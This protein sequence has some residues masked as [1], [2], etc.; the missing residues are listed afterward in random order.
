MKKIYGVLLGGLLFVPLLAGASFDKNLYYGLQKDV[1]VKELQ[2]FLADQGLYSGPITGN[3]FSL[4]LSAVKKFQTANSISP[5]SGYFGPKSRTVANTILA[6]GTAESDVESAQ[7][8]N[9]APTQALGV[10]DIVAQ[11]ARLQEQINAL[12]QSTQQVQQNTQ[13]I[14]QNTTPTPAASSNPT[15]TTEPSNPSTPVVQPVACKDASLT[16]SLDSS[17]PFNGTVQAGANAIFTKLKFAAGS[18]NQGGRPLRKI[19]ITREG[20]TDDMI[21]G[22]SFLNGSSL[23]AT[24]VVFQ[25]GK[26]VIPDFPSVSIVDNS[27]QVFTIKAQLTDKA[28][29]GTQIR[30]G[31]ASSSDVWAPDVCA[32]AN[33]ISTVTLNGSG[34][35]NYMTVGN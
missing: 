23:L 28:T 15:P 26:A 31:I 34:M 16:V 7:D 35:G 8:N 18:G 29:A 32:S 10:S 20:G 5:V 11:I 12:N 13:Q 27:Y 30:M 24:N 1:Q 3:Y 33:T 6:Q 9:P 2:E 4:T 14:A 17:S 22:I 19:T 25:N 21:S